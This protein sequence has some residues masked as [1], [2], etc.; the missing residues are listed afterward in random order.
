M[1]A[2]TDVALSGGEGIAARKALRDCAHPRRRVHRPRSRGVLPRRQVIETRRSSRSGSTSRA[3]IASTFETTVGVLWIV[4]AGVARDRRSA[5]ARAWARPCGGGRWLLFI[6]VPCHRGHLAALLNGHAR[7]HDERVR[8]DASNS[9]CPITLGALAGIL[10]ERS[11]ML[12]IALEGKML[13]GA[14]VASISRQRHAAGDRQP[15]ARHPSS[16]SRRR[17]S[18]GG[19]LGLLLAWLGHPVQGRP[20]HR[21]HRDQHRRDRDHE[22]PLP[23]DPE[24]KYRT[25]HA[26]DDRP[27][28]RPDAG[29][30]PGPGSDPLR[31][32]ALRVHRLHPGHRPHLHALPDPLG[33]PAARVRAR[34]RRR[35]APSGSMSSRSGIARCSSPA[36]SRVWRVPTFRC[37]AAGSF[38]MEHG[39]RQGLHRPGGDDLR[40]LASRRRVRRG[41]RVRLRRKRRSRCCRSSAGGDGAVPPQLLNSIPYLVTII[42][43]A[44]VVGRVRGPAAAGQPY[45]QG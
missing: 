34:S 40:R 15:G 26:P 9:R 19:L 2:A 18:Q 36:S 22:L 37:R 4:A 25:Q 6:V 27:D 20:D 33:P 45:E 16:G 14:C 39:R 42:V 21:R 12:N 11:G 5:P 8:R 32:E 1:T 38:Q 44:G 31:L 30:P 23:A 41:P 24:P 35:L 3:A 29:R 7:E 28:A 13:V 17:S 10:S 43:V